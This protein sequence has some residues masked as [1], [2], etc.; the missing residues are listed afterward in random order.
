ML[1]ILPRVVLQV[2]ASLYYKTINNK[3]KKKLILSF[4]VVTACS[5]GGMGGQGGT[6]AAPETARARC[7]LLPHVPRAAGGG[8]NV[9]SPRTGHSSCQFCFI[10][11][12]SS[13]AARGPLSSHRRGHSGRWRPR[14]RPL[15]GIASTLRTSLCPSEMPQRPP[16]RPRGW[17]R[18]SAKSGGAVGPPPYSASAVSRLGTGSCKKCITALTTFSGAML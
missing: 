16:H 4:P 13:A 7:H 18:C 1:Y 15:F 11:A 8:S 10:D 2:K 9:R 3:T 14:A 17:G 12:K 5:W 6:R